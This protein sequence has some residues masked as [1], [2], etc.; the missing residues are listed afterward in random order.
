MKR[1]KRI[2][3]FGD[4]VGMAAAVIVFVFPFLFM[5]VNSLKDRREANLLSMALPVKPLWSN[6]KEV[7]ESNNYIILTAFKNS[8]LLTVFSLCGLVFVC[9][10]AGYVL[11]RRRGRTM[12]FV[13][14]IIM[15]GLMIPPAILPTIWI[16]QGL[17]I[18]K[19]LFGM[20]LIEIALQIPFDIMIYRGFMSSIPVELEEAGYIDGCSKIRLFSSIIFPLLKP[21]T[22]TIIILN[23][24][25]I[26]NDFTNPLYF[27]P[28]NENTT[29]Q[30]TLYNFKG[31]Y[32][33]SYNL[34]FA[35]VILITIPMLILFLIFNKRIVDGMVAGSVKG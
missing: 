1:K 23:A 3:L 5:L 16:M 20:I 18:Y 32:A 33:S 6:Y 2:L 28:G 4:I 13:N 27:L 24:V 19:T 7:F 14:F 15:T 17:H 26:F 21:A 12:S 22:A 30:L 9:S 29:I 10:M 11:Q 31:Q 25:T 8:L 35:D 34:L